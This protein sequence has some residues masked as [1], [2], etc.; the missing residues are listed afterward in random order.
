MNKRSLARM[1][2]SILASALPLSL[3]QCGNNNPPNCAGA[4]VP[5]GDAGFDDAGGLNCIG[6]CGNTTCS[7]NSDGKTVSCRALCAGRRPCNLSAPT[8]TGGTVLGNHFV[9]MAHLEAASVHAF[10]TL[11]AELCAL[12]APV[13]L[14]RAARRAKRDEIRHARAAG[15]LA[16]RFGGVPLPPVVRKSGRL[17]LID[18]AIENAVEGCVR[19]TFGAMIAQWQACHAGDLGARAAMARIARDETSHAALAWQIHAWARTRLSRAEWGRVTHAMRSA[20]A[21]LSDLSDGETPAEIARVAGL[22][23]AAESEALARALAERL[24]REQMRA[25]AG[26]SQACA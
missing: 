19:E 17:R 3:V 13:R 1:F 26:D 15:A 4:P 6:L 24:W 10:R 2:A 18:I 23:A 7:L 25:G 22:P 8:V 12:H 9:E 20:V 11:A 5:L 21:S 16:R 14:V